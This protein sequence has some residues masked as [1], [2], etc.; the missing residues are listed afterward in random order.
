[1]A[2]RVFIFI[3]LSIDDYRVVTNIY[4]VGSLPVISIS[5]FDDDFNRTNLLIIRFFESFCAYRT[6][7]ADILGSS[8]WNKRLD[9]WVLHDLDRVVYYSDPVF[10]P[11]L[12][13]KFLH[14]VDCFQIVS[15]VYE[16]GAGI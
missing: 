16:E 12:F 7:D 10:C 4:L 3:L 6:E 11:E 2:K 5:R 9:G 8:N 14:E 15:Q 1:M 13:V